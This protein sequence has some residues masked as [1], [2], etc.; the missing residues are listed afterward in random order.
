M[1]VRFTCAECHETVTISTR[2]AGKQGLCPRCRRPVRF[3]HDDVPE[4]DDE[5]DPGSDLSPPPTPS[6]S[7]SP[8]TSP[9]EELEMERQ[10]LDLERA[11]LEYDR[12]EL[13]RK[14]ATSRSTSRSTTV[15]QPGERSRRPPYPA[16]RRR[17][18]PSW[19]V[20]AVVILVAGGV[21]IAGLLATK[22]PHESLST[23]VPSAI[24]GLQ[25][26]YRVV[27]ASGS[28]GQRV[29]IT[30][31]TIEFPGRGADLYEDLGGGRLVIK[32]ASGLGGTVYCW[33]WEGDQLRLWD[34]AFEEHLAIV[35]APQ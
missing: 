1:G 23:L 12:A 16:P 7:R 25:G 10:H 22:K 9:N 5:A 13:E 21:V 28:V 32:P 8:S 19:V 2:W 35:L 29:V 17:G 14:R 18:I 31:R 4:V 27:S 20:I 26:T 30:A 33:R 15:G 11:R 24:R 34:A 3:P 6:R